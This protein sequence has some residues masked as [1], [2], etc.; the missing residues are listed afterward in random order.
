MVNWDDIELLRQYATGRS[1]EAFAALVARH[2]DVVYSAA[3]RQVHNPHWAQEVTQR[4]FILLAQKARWMGKNTILTGW[5]YR[6]TRYVASEVMRSENRRRIR[7]QEAMQTLD[8]PA[9]NSPW[10]EIAPLLDEAMAR[11]NGPDRNA[12][13]LR[14]FKNRNLK[15]LGEAL[16]IKEDAAQKRVARALEKLRRFFAQRGVTVSAVGLSTAMTAFAVKAAPAGPTSSIVMAATTSA[17]GLTLFTLI[18][19]ALEFMSTAKKAALVAAAVVAMMTPTAMQWH[20]ARQLRSENQT[21]RQENQRL[22]GR[23]QE[24]TERAGTQQ[25]RPDT[26]EAPKETGSS[27]PGNRSPAQRPSQGSAAGTPASDETTGQTDPMARMTHA[28]ELKMQG[29][30]AEALQE[31]L[32]CFDEGERKNRGFSGVRVSFLLAEIA[33]LAKQFPPAREALVI[34]RDAAEARV[35]SGSSDGLAVFELAYLNTHLNEADRN[36]ALFDQLPADSPVRGNLVK[37]VSRQFLAAQRY[38]DIV[39]ATEPEAEFLQKVSTV[40]TVGST[41]TNWQTSPLFREANQRMVLQAGSNGV[42]ALA[43][44]GQTDRAI[45]LADKVL[46]ADGSSAA[47]AQLL[48]QAERSGNAEVTAYLKAKSSGSPP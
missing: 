16:G 33:D 18:L 1:N 37:A 41:S 21:L 27:R 8:E 7:E 32:W 30:Y 45:A 6:S 17:T 38:Q 46:Q 4:V 15:E 39:A 5:L 40:V 26:A 48:K 28:R 31:Y 36:L 44:A 10:T 42:E 29:R 25:L 47:L 20:A 24:L 13:L 22:A 23:E 34:R 9:D 43:G 35:R 14:Y 12:L 2:V 19:G 11:L 3:L